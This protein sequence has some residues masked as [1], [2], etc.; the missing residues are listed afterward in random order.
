MGSKADKN[1]KVLTHF[2]QLPVTRSPAVLLCRRLTTYICSDC[3][4][5]CGFLHVKSYVGCDWLFCNVVFTLI[6][7]WEI[8]IIVLL[9]FG[10]GKLP[11]IGKQVGEAISSFKK[12]KEGI[13]DHSTST[14]ETRSAD[15]KKEE[16]EIE[17][18]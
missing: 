9:I 13:E 8:A 4:C 18:V 7:A 11:K 12:A 10:A 3:Y 16:V 2:P 5:I 14:A 15:A 17:P 6:K 1:L